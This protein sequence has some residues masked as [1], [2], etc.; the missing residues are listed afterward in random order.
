MFLKND[1]MKYASSN[2]KQ[3]WCLYERRVDALIQIYNNMREKNRDL[4][5]N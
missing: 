1:E 2:W 4:F 3:T 5:G